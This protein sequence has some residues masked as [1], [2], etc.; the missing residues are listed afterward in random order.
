VYWILKDSRQHRAPF[1]TSIGLVNILPVRRLRAP[2][3]TRRIRVCA[4]R[5]RRTF[6]S[7]SGP[8]PTGSS[9]EPARSDR[10]WRT[11]R[12]RDAC[13]VNT[14]SVRIGSETERRRRLRRARSV[15]T[16][17]A[18]YGEHYVWNA[19]LV[20]S[21]RTGEREDILRVF[22]RGGAEA[23]NP[24]GSRLVR[25]GSPAPGLSQAYPFEDTSFCRRVLQS[26][27]TV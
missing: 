21:Y 13:A 24:I 5:R 12:R 20:S 6:V 22:G 14:S 19:W 7:E 15:T 4:T 1:S 11:F 17:C 9:H 8:Y 26:D 23:L 10:R 25:D 27:H 3:F 2:G 16:D 18:G